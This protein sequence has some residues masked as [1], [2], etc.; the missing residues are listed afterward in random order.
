MDD[1]G[2]LILKKVQME[3]L[4]RPRLAIV[5]SLNRWDREWM[6]AYYSIVGSVDPNAPEDIDRAEALE[7]QKYKHD[8]I[9]E[10]V[11]FSDVG[12]LASLLQEAE[13]MGMP[14]LPGKRPQPEAVD[15]P[16]P[17]PQPAEEAVPP[18]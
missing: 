10:L 8:S 9:M 11:A 14:S 6:T 18:N 1:E 5:N 15:P 3:I 13:D 2:K 12:E 17:G 16:D 4:A 7:E